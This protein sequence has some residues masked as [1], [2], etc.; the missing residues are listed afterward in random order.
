M[1]STNIPFLEFENEGVL[2]GNPTDPKHVE[3]YALLRIAQALEKIAE[4]H[5][6]VVSL[7]SAISKIQVQEDQ[8]LLK[9]KDYYTELIAKLNGDLSKMKKKNF[10]LQKL[11]SHL[12]KLH[13]GEE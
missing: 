6:T 11:I 5:T 8:E 12:Q 3:I 1:M 13:K 10:S 2:K 4:S 9:T 7:V